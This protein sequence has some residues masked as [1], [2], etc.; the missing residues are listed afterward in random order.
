MNKKAVAI[1]VTIILTGVVAGA[2][3][4]SKNKTPDEGEISQAVQEETTAETG[5]TKVSI[6]DLIA[7]GIPQK[8]TLEYSNE[9]MASTSETWIKGRKYKQFM[10]VESPV[11][12]KRSVYT[13][14]D[15]VYIYTWE[16]SA[17][18]GNKIKIEESE[19]DEPE[20]TDTS[21]D[22]QMDDVLDY[23]C[24]PAVI[25]DSEFE[26]PSD[27]V[28]TDVNAELEKLQDQMEN[29]NVENLMQNIPQE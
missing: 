19:V 20:T 29:L 27:I 10:V 12:G 15:G 1:G 6:K 2:L 26:I 3:I 24:A 9:D 11:S 8:C 13:V 7:K 21:V 23:K 5:D 4:L 25:T 16:E 22:V 17:K 28:F 14:S 18:T